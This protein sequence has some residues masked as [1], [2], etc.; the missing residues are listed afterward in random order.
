MHA[1][2]AVNKF[3]NVY[4]AG[5]AGEHVSII[6]AHVFDADEKINHLTHGNT[7]GFMQLRM[8]AHADVMRGR[9]SARILLARGFMHDEL[10]RPDQRS[11][12]RGDVNF[13]IALA[14][15]SVANFKQRAARAWIDP[16]LTVDCFASGINVS[17]HTKTI[18]L[19]N[20]TQSL[21]NATDWHVR[22]S[23]TRALG[24]LGDRRSIEPLTKALKDYS[25][26]VRSG[27][28]QALGQI[29]ELAIA[30]LIEALKNSD[31]YVRSLAARALGQIGEPTVAPLIE[32]LKDQDKGVRSN[33]AQALG[34]I[35]DPRAVA[36][37]I[38]ALKDQDKGVRSNAAQALGRIDDPRAVAPLIEALK[39]QDKGVR[40]NAA[41]ALGQIDDPGAV[42][43]LIEA[44]KDQDKG[45]RSNAE[46]GVPPVANSK[47][48][49]MA[50]QYGNIGLQVTRNEAGDFTLYPFHK[51]PAVKAGVQ[52][53]DIL[54]RVNDKDI[55]TTM[56]Q[57]AVEQ[58][59][60]G[61]VKDN[62]GV[63]VRVKRHASKEEKDFTIPF[64]A[65]ER[66]S[67]MRRTMVEEP[68]FGYI[69]I[70]FFIS[71]TPD[72]LKNAIADLKSKQV[73]ALVL[74]LRNN[75]G[76]LLQESLKVMEQ[77]IDGGVVLY[78]KTDNDEKMYEVE[79]GNA[80][81]LPLVVLV[82]G[83]RLRPPNSLQP[84]SKTVSELLSSGSRVT[85]KGR[86]D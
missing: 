7:R 83:E 30:P 78:E 48:G 56:Q 44:L 11:F 73:S 75:P 65:T 47:S 35:D 58:M 76:G 84:L 52:D 57:D 63:R 29:G 37:L 25:D 1:F 12:E 43:A 64:A 38:E 21:E 6:A 51:G 62:N 9:L 53:G 23:A 61:E 41:Q 10:K 19:Q 22:F 79:K 55:P 13:A 70:M 31:W 2:V 24:K 68:T 66:P 42:A 15:V 45:V 18:I 86:A 26:E 36:P 59:L 71:R 72:E 8:K 60:H 81:D 16:F 28:V 50:G 3:S 49:V 82:N 69:Q 67:V 46:R 20:L 85:G 32:A 17:E 77:F 14:G 39:D 33:A 40:S 27:A 5:D 54:V 80:T 74:D 34:R 4:V